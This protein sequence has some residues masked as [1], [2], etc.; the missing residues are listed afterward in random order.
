MRRIITT[1]FHTKR[2]CGEIESSFRQHQIFLVSDAPFPQTARWH[3]AFHG[4]DNHTGYPKWRA[5]GKEL[6]HKGRMDVEEK[7]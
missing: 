7:L 4:V 2:V 3:G 5:E 1:S 6:M